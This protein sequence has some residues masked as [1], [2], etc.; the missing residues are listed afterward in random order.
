LSLSD[1][2]RIGESITEAAREAGTRETGLAGEELG[3]VTMN[4]LE[5][6]EVARTTAA[7]LPTAKAPLEE[8]VQ[9]LGAADQVLLRKLLTEP[10]D[11]VDHPD[12][13][14]RG[15]EKNLFGATARFKGPESNRFEE[16]PDALVDSLGSAGRI[17]S[18]SY[19]DERHLFMR[20]NFARRHVTT[21]LREFAGRRLTPQ[22]TRMLLAWGHRTL[23]AR[24]A[25]VRL[26]MPLV[27]AM[28]KRTRLTHVDFNEL[29]SEGNM[30]LLRSVE[31]F[32]C[33]RG[34]KFSTYSCRAILKSFSR[35]AMRAS[36]YRG[37]FP[38]EFDPSMER[39]DFSDRQR[40]AVERDCVDELKEIL[41]RNT[42]GLSDVEHRVI[43]ER[44]AIGST[45]MGEAAGP[46]TLEQ[47]G[48]IIGV[49]KER[50]R[51]IQNKAL[52]KIRLAL[53]AGYLAA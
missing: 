16:R 38:M 26:N 34:Y 41:I 46:K 21:I 33:A 43:S 51:Q 22:A 32:D 27:F 5:S 19:A 37:Q 29:I 9:A 36:R 15:I 20:Y 11:Y 7:R 14:K 2:V 31:K 1:V 4:L 23:E 8:T 49:T 13:G 39:S 12:F 6:A 44:F 25:I 40:E 17:P 3:E 10:T 47:V 53:E 28:A 48:V 35:V 50:V 30:A 52:R 45:F 18:L 42:A 24:G